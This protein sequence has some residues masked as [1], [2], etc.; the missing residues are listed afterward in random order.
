[1][2]QYM[3]AKP[4]AKPITVSKHPLGCIELR[5]LKCGELIHNEYTY[6][7][8][9]LIGYEYRAYFHNPCF[10]ELED[11]GLIVQFREVKP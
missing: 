10:Q 2:E 5:C 8:A 6:L 9:I 11:K 1:M 3:V 4:A 7:S